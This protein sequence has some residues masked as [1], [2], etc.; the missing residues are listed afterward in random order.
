MNPMHE[1]I[2][3]SLQSHKE[4]MAS[5]LGLKL[6]VKLEVW[7]D[8]TSGGFLATQPMEVEGLH[9][10]PSLA[11]PMHTVCVRMSG[12]VIDVIN[13]LAHEMRHAY[14]YENGLDEHVVR[15]KL[16]AFVVNTVAKVNKDVAA[17][18]YVNKWVEVDA[19]VYAAWYVSGADTDCPY[20]PMIEDMRALYPH[21]SDGELRVL[22]T[23]MAYEYERTGMPNDVI[24]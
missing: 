10:Q 18:Q 15:N 23:R 1:A 20:V 12:D 11:F 3:D 17:L 6:P 21:L 19:R 9:F 7:F 4:D 8:E 2:Y 13:S 5:L 22:R 16:H 24:N 14:Q